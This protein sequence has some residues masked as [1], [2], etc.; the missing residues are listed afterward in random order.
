MHFGSSLMGSAL[1]AA[2]PVLERCYLQSHV[3][4]KAGRDWPR[5]RRRMAEKTSQMHEFGFCM[6]L[7]EGKADLGAIAVPLYIPEQPPLAVACIGRA[8][9][10]GARPCR[11]RAR[12]RPTGDGAG[13]AGTPVSRG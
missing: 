6:S 7:G 13:A 2:I 9:R 10:M 5:L 4:R 8:A 1:L 12:A 11:T 3:E